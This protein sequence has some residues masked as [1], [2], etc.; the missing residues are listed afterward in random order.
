DGAAHLQLDEPTWLDVGSGE[1]LLE[2]PTTHSVR[3]VARGLF[4]PFRRQV[5]HA[6]FHRTDLVDRRR[7]LALW[8]ALALLGLERAPADF[9]ELKLRWRPAKTMAFANSRG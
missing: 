9:R 4:G 7:A 6:H 8:G 2:L 1:R 3:M 5:G